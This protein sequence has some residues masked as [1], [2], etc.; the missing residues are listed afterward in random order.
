[1]NKYVE[2]VVEQKVNRTLEALNRHGFKAT[3][4]DS[5]EE[6]FILVKSLIKKGSII[7]VGGSETLREVGLLEEFKR[8]ITILF[9]LKQ[10]D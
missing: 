9:K 8:A 7:G 6:A 5:K 10:R 3:C 1:M 4:V 2:K